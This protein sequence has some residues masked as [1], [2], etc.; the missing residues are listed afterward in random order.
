MG[1]DQ[2]TEHGCNLLVLSDCDYYSNYIEVAKLQSTT[3]RNVIREMKKVFSLDLECQI[4]SVVT[5]DHSSHLLS[6]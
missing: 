5:T 3:A 2:C 1:V 4:S 6:L